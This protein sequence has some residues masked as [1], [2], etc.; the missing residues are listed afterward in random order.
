MVRPVYDKDHRST[1]GLAL[2]GSELRPDDTFVLVLKAKRRAVEDRR[3][4]REPRREG[5]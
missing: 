3:Q 5:A 2:T 4:K 1:L